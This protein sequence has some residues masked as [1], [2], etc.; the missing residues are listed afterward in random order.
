MTTFR[1]MKLPIELRLTIYDFAFE[2]KYKDSPICQERYLN[3]DLYGYWCDKQRRQ[4]GDWDVEFLTQHH[5]WSSTA[6][7]MCSKQVYNEALPILYKKHQVDLYKPDSP[8]HN[9]ITQRDPY[10]LYRIR[11]VHTHFSYVLDNITDPS[12]YGTNKLSLICQTCPYLTK[13]TIT[14]NINP[15]SRENEPQVN[16]FRLMLTWLVIS[17]SSPNGKPL[18]ITAEVESYGRHREHDQYDEVDIA[19]STVARELHN[20]E[21]DKNPLCQ[22]TQLKE[23]TMLLV[24]GYDEF[25]TLGNIKLGDWGFELSHHHYPFDDDPRSLQRARFTWTKSTK[26]GLPGPRKVDLDED[27]RLCGQSVY[28]QRF[29][30]EQLGIRYPGKTSRRRRVVKDV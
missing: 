11:N 23:I 10:A 6:I 26:Q 14:P 4:F 2:S 20:D 3:P 25:D 15:S 1:F 17:A 29:S 16:I 21:F 22:L 5:Q 30:P 8:Y 18:H 7:L 12:R 24:V 19:K 27:I 28:N 9:I 13:L